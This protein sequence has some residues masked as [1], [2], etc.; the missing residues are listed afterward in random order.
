MESVV[1]V[2]S[3]F[4]IGLLGSLHCVGMC[5]PI[6][7]SL[8]VHNTSSFSK[9]LNIIIYNFG[10]AI[11]YSLM[12]LVMGLLGSS[13]HFF[14]YQQLLSIVAGVLIL[15]FALLYFFKPS[16]INFSIGNSTIVR[17][18]SQEMKKEKS[19]KTF[20][21]IGFL[22]GFLPCGLVYMALITAF[23]TGTVFKGSMFM[24]FF[25]LGTIPMMAGVMIAGKW[26][27]QS[28]KDVFKKIVPI[29]IVVMGVIL[30]LRGMNLGI[31]YISPSY[32]NDS[33]CVESCCEHH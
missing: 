24:F 30:V 25:G 31:P 23:A 4:S 20:F 27:S 26:I 14:G 2:I 32:N 28:T 33:H 13:F 21:T 5:G 1:T 18:L 3:G 29:W 6:A 10:R 16:A 15:I 22:N 9:Y 19:F 8:P 11:A 12:G 7:L 17:K